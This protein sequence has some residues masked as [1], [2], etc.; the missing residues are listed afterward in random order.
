MDLASI[1]SEAEDHF[2]GR[3]MTRSRVYGLW[4]GGQICQAPGC[5]NDGRAE[6]VWE[7]V[8]HFINRE[9]RYVNW[10]GSGAKSVAQPD[11]FTMSEKCLAVLN[12]WYGDGISWH[13]F[14]CEDP[15][16][17]VCEKVL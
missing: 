11:D 10:S 12:N 5:V 6:W 1:E 17:F 9:D 4:T 2:L 15:L 14:T 16:P 3:F 7:P 13:D 8:A